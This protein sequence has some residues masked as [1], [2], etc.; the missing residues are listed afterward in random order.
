MKN[1]SKLAPDMDNPPRVNTEKT[2]RGTGHQKSYL[3]K[4]KMGRYSS[5][6]LQVISNFFSI[7]FTVC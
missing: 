4:K 2:K 6:R 3:K 7:C 1:N 5:A